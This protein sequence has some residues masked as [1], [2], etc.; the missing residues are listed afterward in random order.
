[1]V[2]RVKDRRRHPRVDGSFGAKITSS[3]APIE[4]SVKNVS[5][6]G[7]LLH[8]DKK[9]DEMTMVSMKLVLPSKSGNTSPSVAFD[10]TGAVVRCQPI[11]KGKTKKF[12]LAVYF[13]DLPRETRG[14]LEEF[15]RSRLD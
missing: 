13:T 8:S 1:M 10:L 7:L 3:S 14:A 2:E 4:A 15:V 11:G 6:S 5:M 12:E 9:V